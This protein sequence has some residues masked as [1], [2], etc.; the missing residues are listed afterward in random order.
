MKSIE[1]LYLGKR[2]EKC[3][4]PHIRVWVKLVTEHTVFCRK[5]NLLSQFC[6]FGGKSSG[7]FREYNF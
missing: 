1:F 2:L 6:I 3:H 5:F 7:K 4:H